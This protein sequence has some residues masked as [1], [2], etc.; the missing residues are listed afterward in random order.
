MTSLAFVKNEF[1]SFSEVSSGLLPG[2]LWIKAKAFTFQ[3]HVWRHWLIC[4]NDTFCWGSL[5]R[6]AWIW[7]Q[8][9]SIPLITYD[10]KATL[11]SFR[12]F[13]LVFRYSLSAH[14]IWNTK[15]WSRRRFWLTFRFRL[16]ILQ[17]QMLLH[18]RWSWIKNI[19][20]L[21]MKFRWS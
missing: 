20:A 8:E 16:H 2:L 5:I 9:P 17:P 3:V 7:W 6:K 14:Q 4:L 10:E 21:C 18:K 15:P 1:L 19:K 12:G 13:W 11:D